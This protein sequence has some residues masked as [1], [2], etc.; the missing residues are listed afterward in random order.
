[1]Y[2]INKLLNIYEYFN[3]VRC[4]FTHIHVLTKSP[5]IYIYIY[6]MQRETGGERPVRHVRPP[7]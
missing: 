5:Y 4:T 1:M 2:I 6:I 3:I 7:R